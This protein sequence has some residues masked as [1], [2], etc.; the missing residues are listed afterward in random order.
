M[1]TSNNAPF[2]YQEFTGDFDAQM[3][4]ASMTSANYHVLAILA[5]DPSGEFV[6]IGK[7][8]R[9]GSGDFAQSRSVDNGVTTEQTL[10]GDFSHYRLV[11][12]ADEFR[13][14]VSQDGLFWRQV[15]AYSRPDLPAMLRVGVTQASFGGATVTAQVE[16]FSLTPFTPLPGDY[17]ADGVV[18][19]AD[20]AVWRDTLDSTT[21]LRADGDRSG[22]VDQQDYQLWRTQFGEASP[23]PSQGSS[24]NASVPS[25]SGL[26]L[27]GAAALAACCRPSRAKPL[28]G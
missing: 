28:L 7:Q 23:A 6:W 5:Q 20:Y 12:E 9:T 11:R 24:T 3:E 26:S 1:P 17:N 18:D 8:D 19:A 4:I 22:R 15:A 13:G 25:P 16:A 10:S 14:Y 21:D 27:A 2:L